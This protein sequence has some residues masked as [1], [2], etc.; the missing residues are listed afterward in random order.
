MKNELLAAKNEKLIKKN[1]ADMFI[2][3]MRTLMS[4]NINVDKKKIN[5]EI[6]DKQVELRMINE[7][8]EKIDLKIKKRE[9]IFSN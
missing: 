3:E 1:Y 4:E 2:D 8:I 6:L 7:D 5:N 9:T